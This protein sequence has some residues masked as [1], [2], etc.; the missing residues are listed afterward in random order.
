M[1]KTRKEKVYFIL[2]AAVV[3]AIIAL[4]I[5]WG[6]SRSRAAEKKAAE[7]AAAP[8]AVVNAQPDRIVVY[9][10]VEVE[11]LIEVEKTITGAII[12]DGLNDMGFLV[13]QEYYFTEVTGFSSVKKLFNIELKLT[14][15]GYLAGY[16]GAIYAGVDFTKINVLKDEDS[17]TVIITVPKAEI[18]SIEIDFDSFVLYS[19][20]EGLGNPISV[21]DYNQSMVELETTAREKA[22]SRGILD[23]A[24]ENA[25]TVIR[26]FVSGFV[27]TN[28][29]SVT[30]ITGA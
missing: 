14:E 12:Q 5:T 20:K 25:E 3:L 15:S 16:D 27:D 11:K 8:A 21:A 29:Y 17:K 4:F 28:E 9:E 22:V 1:P 6:V 30:V 18:Q 13:T 23:K 7:A 2:I 26:N 24:E 10:E 19:E